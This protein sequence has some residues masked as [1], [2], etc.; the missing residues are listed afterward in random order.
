[1]AIL[2]AGASDYSRNNK[3]IFIGN[4]CRRYSYHAFCN[5]VV[6]PTAELELGRNLKPDSIAEGNDVYFECRI[7]SN[8]PPLRFLWTH[9]VAI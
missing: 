1:M 3:C 2:L 4:Y 8:P 9:E 5:D 6:A 7:R